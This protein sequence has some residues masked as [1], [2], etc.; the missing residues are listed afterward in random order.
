MRPSRVLAVAVPALVAV[1]AWFAS[2]ALS[3]LPLST[4]SP[5]ISKAL[6]LAAPATIQAPLDAPEPWG[7]WVAAASVLAVAG[8]YACFAAVFRTGRGAAG[9]AAGWLAA[10]LA[11]VVAV[12]IPTGV[13]VAGAVLDRQLQAFPSV[14]VV[15]AAAYWGVVWGWMPALAGALL[16][17]ARATP[18]TRAPGRGRGIL[19]AS[20]ATI[21]VLGLGALA[22]A[23]PLALEAQRAVDQAVIA[24]SEPAPPEPIGVPI[25]EIAPGD[26]QVDPS[27]CTENQLDFS[28]SRPDAAAGHRGM[29]IT[30]TNTSTAPCVIEGYP[31]LAFSDPVTNG[32][33]TRVLHGG[34]MLA[35]PDAGPV[36]LDVAPGA[37]VV[38]DLS[39]RAPARSDRDPAGFVHVAAYPGAVRQFVQV[40]TDITGGELEVTAW[41]AA[42]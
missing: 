32:F 38:A 35:E 8:G 25:P 26:W 13:Q 23:T 41:R 15:G 10:V 2:D 33:E 20:S 31:D 22:I 6:R 40:D 30:A 28:A 11:G 29:R 1:A 34:G 16:A 9:F 3:Q 39:W 14:E 18:A 27:W 17:R 21:A 12:G 5:T 37:S 7:A 36:R 4:P 24:Q 19:I 42:G